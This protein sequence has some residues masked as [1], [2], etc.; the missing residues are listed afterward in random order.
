MTLVIRI[1]LKIYLYLRTRSQNITSKICS[2]NSY[3]K[4]ENPKV[5]ESF[6]IV[7]QRHPRNLVIINLVNLVFSEV[8]LL[9]VYNTGF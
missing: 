4:E 3:T 9:M 5:H 6:Q 2:N 1:S 8:Y 7:Q